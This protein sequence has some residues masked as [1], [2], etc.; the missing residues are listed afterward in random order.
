MASLYLG[1][2]CV[3][4][5]GLAFEITL[6]R[7]FAVA[8][9][10]H[11]GF[12]AVSFALIGFGASGTAL[13]LRPHSPREAESLCTPLARLAV[14]FSLS[15]VGSYLAVN[16]LPF[17]S[18]RIAW[19]RLQLVYL[20]LYYLALVLPFLLGGLALGLPLAALPARTTSVYAANL[21]GSG[22]GCLAGLGALAVCDVPG[23]VACAALLAALGA[24]A[25]AAGEWGH[26]R[27]PAD[28]AQAPSVPF[29]RRR[30]LV[31]APPRLAVVSIALVALM[32]ALFVAA[33]PFFDVQVSPYKSLPQLLRLADAR[34]LSRTWNAYSRVEVVE[35]TSVRSAPGLSLTYTQALARQ[36][37]L[38]Q[39]ADSVTPL[40][41]AAPAA[42]LDALPVTLAYRLR[43]NARVLMIAPG[44]GIELLAALNGGAREIVAVEDNPLIAQA[45]QS[46]APHAFGD[47]RVRVVAEGTRAWLARSSDRFDVVHLALA[48][49]FRPATAGAY[50]LGENYV[51]TQEAFREYL[52]LLS[53]DG[54]LIASR[55]LQLPP[56]EEV[57]LGALAVAALV[58]E[59]GG[60]PGSR[61]LALR[62]FS[63]LLLLVKRT[64]FTAGEIEQAMTF[65]DRYQFDWVARPGLAAEQ[66][67]RFSV[68]RQDEYYAAFQQ[69]LN[70][71]EMPR[72]VADYAYDVTPPTDD[73]PFF[74]HLFKWEQTPQAVQLLGKLWQPFG[75][76]GYLVLLAL[77]VLSLAASSGL[78]L[79]PLFA[80]RGQGHSGG[81]AWAV[82]F[83]FL[84]VG[85]LFVEIPLIQRF[86]LFLDRPVYA[87]AVVLFALLV[88]SGVG[89]SLSDRLPPRT[90]LALLAVV[91]VVFPLL[92][93]VVFQTFLGVDLTLRVLLSLVLIAPVGFLMGIPFPRGLAYLGARAPGWVPLAWGINGCASVVSSILATIGA[94]TWGFSAVL[95]AGAVVYSLAALICPGSTERT[96]RP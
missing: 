62:S 84:G 73:R 83:A 37:G 74:F 28:A 11:F 89:S 77:L 3:A 58:G 19:E 46:Y 43:P 26:V 65:A 45:A 23:A 72:F 85:Y 10:Y 70:P 88:A 78:I 95:F 33:P 52:S 7:L 76:S 63:T 4:A 54:I 2:A 59:G 86:V 69:V 93:P 50:A 48:D 49:P 13:A 18:Y 31:A 75:G 30:L 94:L 21:A 27:G 6:T 17:D 60:E 25:F 71:R 35:S 57:R 9:G 96:A 92:L 61:V 20:A 90:A 91:I 80:L 24:V 12:L 66:A 29:C 87:F 8:Q 68:L 22:L 44:G 64:P 56:S 41:D 40:T 81:R 82:Y 39:D 14:L 5:A 42:L 38:F 51:Y 53:E 32:G 55:W 47:S 79:I 67:N 16:Y 1:V 15:L 34:V 36:R